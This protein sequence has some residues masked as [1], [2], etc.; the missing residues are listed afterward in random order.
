VF[1]M[2]QRGDG[3]RKSR[4][5]AMVVLNHKAS[6]LVPRIL[7][8]VVTGSTLYN[9]ALRSYRQTDRGFIHDFIDHSVEYVNGRVHTNTVENFWSCV[10]QTQH[11]TY[12]AVRSSRLR[13]RAARRSY[14]R[15]VLQHYDAHRLCLAKRCNAVQGDP[16]RYQ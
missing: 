14:P 4:A 11:G 2:L 13:N 3:K 7:D 6:S 12:I 15:H 16:L 5:R 1:G 8:N 10:K 9:D